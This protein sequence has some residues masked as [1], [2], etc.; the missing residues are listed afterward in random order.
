MGVIKLNGK[1]V[2]GTAAPCKGA[3]TLHQTFNLKPP[4]LASNMASAKTAH[5]HA[6]KPAKPAVL[7]PRRRVVTNGNTALVDPDTR[8]K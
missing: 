6:A 7:N 4:S 8:S 2:F 5:K 1:Y 3:S